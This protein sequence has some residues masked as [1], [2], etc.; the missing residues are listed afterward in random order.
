MGFI[1]CYVYMYRQKFSSYIIVQ[2]KIAVWKVG[3]KKNGHIYHL[4]ECTAK[5]KVHV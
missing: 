3:E 4:L 2:K 1:I 5:N